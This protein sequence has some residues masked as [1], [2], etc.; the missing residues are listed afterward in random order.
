MKIFLG[1]DGL[2]IINPPREK[3]KDIDAFPIPDRMGID[4]VKY[5][6]AWKNFHGQSTLSV[7]TQ[8]G[9]PYTCKWCSTAVYGQSYRRR[10]P[11]LVVEELNMLMQQYNPDSFWFV[12]DVFTISHKWLEEFKNELKNANLKIQFECITR[13]DRLNEEVIGILKEAGCFRVWIGAESGAQE[14]IDAMDRRVDVLK[15]REMIKLS[16][17]NGIQAGTFIMLGYPGE[18][19]KNIEETIEHLKDSMPD[20]FTIT[21]AYPIKGTGLFKEIETKQINVPEWKLSTDRDRDFKRTYPRIYYK[22]AVSKVVNEVN[23]QK[24]KLN[25]KAFTTLAMKQYFRYRLSGLI[26]DTMEIFTPIKKKE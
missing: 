8:R 7:S 11:A 26:M 16:R 23:F 24:H 14:V 19:R 2:E 5:I 15:V 18:T 3:L 10:K 17:K 25:G 22:F 9:C 20:Y 13:A 21:V 6:D 1:D 4:M 12:D